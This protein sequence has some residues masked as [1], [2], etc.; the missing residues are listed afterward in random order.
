MPL[1][2]WIYK[3]AASRGIERGAE[4]KL[5]ADKELLELIRNRTNRQYF[6]LSIEI[7]DVLSDLMNFLV[8]WTTPGSDAGSL[9]F[10]L[11]LAVAFLSCPAGVFGTFM[12]VRI[13]SS[14]G[15][16]S[17][18]DQA[19]LQVYAKAL[20]DTAQHISSENLL[21][22]LDLLTMDLTVVDLA[23]RGALLEDLPSIIVNLFYSA[24]NGVSADRPSSLAPLFA[25]LISVF[26]VG[27]K[28]SL[29]PKRFD[30]LASKRAVEALL[31]AA[32]DVG[33]G[34][35]GEGGVGRALSGALCTQVFGREANATKLQKRDSK[36][37]L[38]G[39]E[40]GGEGRGKAKRQGSKV[41]DLEASTAA[42]FADNIVMR[43]A[44]SFVAILPEAGGA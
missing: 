28:S 40:E 2:V 21:I 27:K 15:K 34:G 20:G 9:Q 37:R 36:V 18:C 13:I 44:R 43:S 3:M 35:E 19:T 41:K 25:A 11:F 10:I 42:P 38:A 32:S 31:A 23:L 33:E 1:S 5:S 12:R 26:L 16:I 7:L 4:K 30:L 17:S 29:L 22:R 24:V 8:F 6:W 39:V 14:Y